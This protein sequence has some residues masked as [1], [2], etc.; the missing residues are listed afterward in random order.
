MPTFTLIFLTSQPEISNAITMRNILLFLLLLPGFLLA[1]TESRNP[2]KLPLISDQDSYHSSVNDDPDMQ[3]INLETAIPGI[4]LD[5]RYATHNNFTGEIIYPKAAAWARKPLAE[6]L[7]KAQKAF[8]SKGLS[9]KAFDAYRPYAATLRFYEVYPDTNFVAA[10][11]HGSRHNRGAAVDITLVD[12]KTGKELPMPTA[13]DDF[14][15]KAAPDYPNLPD[16]VIRN[17]NLLITTMQQFGFS[18]YP[19]EWWHFDYIGWEKF[20]LMDLSFDE[21]EHDQ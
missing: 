4:I 6:A 15:E 11:W 14:T 10:P 20:P 12:L 16:E 19:H 5:I 9:I 17:R 2:Y 13:F 18:V 21:L 7:A 3:M 8:N 1:Q